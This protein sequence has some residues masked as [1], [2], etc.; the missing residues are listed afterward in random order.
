MADE[1][2]KPQGQALFN[3]HTFWGSILQIASGSGLTAT[4]APFLS[5]VLAAHGV[6]NPD[7]LV[8]AAGM[9]GGFVWTLYGRMNASVPITGVLKAN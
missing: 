3:S 7:A 4:I 1:I 5:A 6:Q 8:N 9:L 2:V